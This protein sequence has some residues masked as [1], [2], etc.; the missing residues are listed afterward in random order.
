MLHAFLGT[1][2]SAVLE[3]ARASSAEH[4]TK[5]PQANV[6]TL[7]S[8]QVAG[9]LDALLDAQGLFARTNV[10]V[11]KWPFET[12]EGKQHVLDRLS[13]LSESSNVFILASSKVDQKTH[14]K[15]EQFAADVQTFMK[16]EEQGYNGS[17]F[18]LGDQ[19]A[20]RDKKT[21]WVSYQ[22]ALHTG[23]RAEEVH[24]ILFWAVKS[25]LVASRSNSAS[26]AGMKPF[27]YTK[28]N[29]G[30]GNYTTSELSVMSA[31]LVSMYHEAHLGAYD[32]ATKLEEWVLSR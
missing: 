4:Q 6:L 29:K 2:T 1:D 5:H 8:D 26:E 28:F 7:E 12:A 25:M 21:L 22:Q 32:L 31:E 15:I 30:A 27:V 18:V 13:A 20:Q 19:L 11:L 17:L 9:E 10:V 3:A 16:T 24:G 23:S 14:K